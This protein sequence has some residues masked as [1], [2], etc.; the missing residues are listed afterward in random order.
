MIME[1]MNED[2]TWVRATAI[3]HDKSG[4][5]T[6]PSNMLVKIARKFSGVA[7][8]EKAGEKLNAKSL[9]GV[10][11]LAAGPNSEVIIHA[12][13]AGAESVIAEIVTFLSKDFGPEVWNATNCRY[14][15]ED[16]KPIFIPA[17]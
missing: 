1:E 17:A 16:E 12:R 10:L 3:V 8:L 7:L 15:D 2:Q 5:C 9:Q 14:A 11:M 6:R 4:L 13:G